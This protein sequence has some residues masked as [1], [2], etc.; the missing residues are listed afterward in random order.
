MVEVHDAWLIEMLMHI[1]DVIDFG[2]VSFYICCLVE[3][4]CAATSTLPLVAVIIWELSL[5]CSMFCFSCIALKLPG[6]FGCR[7][8]E[9]CCFSVRVLLHP[10][11]VFVYFIYQVLWLSRANILA[12]VT[13]LNFLVI[14]G[15]AQNTSWLLVLT[16]VQH[17]SPIE[18]HL[19]HLFYHLL[20][21]C[22]NSI[23][24][25]LW[26][27]NLLG[28][29]RW[30]WW[31]HT[32]G[33]LW[34]CLGTSCSWI[35]LPRCNL[36]SMRWNDFGWRLLHSLGGP[37]LARRHRLSGLPLVPCRWWLPCWLYL[38]LHHLVALVLS[39][40]LKL[41]LGW[42]LD[43][44]DVLYWVD[45]RCD[46][47]VCDII[48]C[49][50]FLRVS[51]FWTIKALDS[52]NISWRW[53]TIWSLMGLE[54][55]WILAHICK[56]SWALWRWALLWD[57]VIWPSPWLA[58]EASGRIAQLRLRLTR[59]TSWWLITV[60]GRWLQALPWRHRIRS[61]RLA[62]IRYGLF[63]V[64]VNPLL[65]ATLCCCLACFLEVIIVVNK[66]LIIFCNIE[67][68]KVAIIVVLSQLNNLFL[69]LWH[70]HNVLAFISEIL[71]LCTSRI[72][73]FGKS[74]P[75][76]SYASL[77]AALPRCLCCYHLFSCWLC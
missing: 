1:Y 6:L 36:S 70:R 69:R 19:F 67:I 13:I 76:A 43:L 8:G 41:D 46:D 12:D 73:P 42:C 47:S 59:G 24:T 15:E 25:P 74:L 54:F 18:P 32:I 28:L 52:N 77:S 20:R 26:W 64:N 16:A 9:L 66:L 11:L 71:T 22:P 45:R 21:L 57:L 53:R 49:I 62:N 72:G 38:L 34:L 30:A 65:W 37:W 27:C 33:P 63:L 5:G 50:W 4:P 14:I 23:G 56:K 7:L 68:L 75:W 10:Q 29:V 60:L 17:S 2:N 3:L 48:Y 39:Y 55:P 35:K 44:I 51:A 61:L 58:R 40:R 31:S